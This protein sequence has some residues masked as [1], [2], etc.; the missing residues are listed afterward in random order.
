MQEK[1]RERKRFTHTKSLMGY[2][3]HKNLKRITQITDATS[4]RR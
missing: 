1:E 3:R 4:S 2:K